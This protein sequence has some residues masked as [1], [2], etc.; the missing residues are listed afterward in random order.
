VANPTVNWVHENSQIA[1]SNTSQVSREMVTKPVFHKAV[2]PS[3]VNVP[4][5]ELTASDFLVPEDKIAHKPMVAKLL[6]GR[7]LESE[8]EQ[9]ILSRKLQFNKAYHE[10]KRLDTTKHQKGAQKASQT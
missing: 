4:K 9:I 5:K 6:S 3:A 8:A 1:I 7:S 2:I 10:H